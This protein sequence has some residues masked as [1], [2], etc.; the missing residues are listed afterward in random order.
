MKHFSIIIFL[1][2]L[3]TLCYAQKLIVEDV[4]TGKQRKIEIGKIVTVITAEDSMANPFLYYTDS[5]HLSGR[6][7]SNGCYRLVDINVDKNTFTIKR[8]SLI[9][10]YSIK[11][12]GEIRYVKAKHPY[13]IKAI[14]A[15]LATAGTFILV[16]RTIKLDNNDSVEEKVAGYGMGTALVATSLLM[17]SNVPRT[18]KVIGIEK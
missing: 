1:L 8:D 7:C 2:L 16:A 6:Y 15:V 13:G 14:R 17:R 12:V 18:Y 9:T 4:K 3:A 10:E 11:D 5:T